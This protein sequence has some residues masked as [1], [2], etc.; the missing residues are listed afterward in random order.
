MIKRL[1]IVGQP[2]KVLEQVRELE[3]KGPCVR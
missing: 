1:C 2:A 3:R